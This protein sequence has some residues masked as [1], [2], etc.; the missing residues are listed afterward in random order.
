MPADVSRW[1]VY[2]ADPASN[3]VTG[4]VIAIDGGLSLA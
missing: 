1:I 4:Q 3:W 2:L